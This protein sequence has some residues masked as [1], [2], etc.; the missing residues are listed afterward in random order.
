MMHAAHRPRDDRG[1]FFM[2]TTS[3]TRADRET[4]RV[5]HQLSETQIQGRWGPYLSPALGHWAPRSVGRSA[6][7]MPPQPRC[8]GNNRRLLDAARRPRCTH[9]SPRCRVG[10][11]RDIMRHRRPFGSGEDTANA[12]SRRSVLRLW[13]VLDTRIMRH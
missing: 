6:R 4:L 1:R 8:Q 13:C 9:A 2:T 5:R 3:C 11:P 7:A 12:C 10:F